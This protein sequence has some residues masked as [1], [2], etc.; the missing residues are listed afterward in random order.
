M[1]DLQEGFVDVWLSLE[2]ILDLV[3]IVD[4][5][6]KLNRL[7]VLQGWGGSQRDCHRCM[8]LDWWRTWWC[9]W[10]NRGSLLAGRSMCLQ[11]WWLRRQEVMLEIS[12]LLYVGNKGIFILYMDHMEETTQYATVSDA[13][14]AT[15]WIPQIPLS[16]NITT[17]QNL[18]LPHPGEQPLPTY[19]PWLL[20]LHL[21]KRLV[22]WNCYWILHSSREFEQYL[23]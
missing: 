1:E 11:L 22:F 8:R 14:S 15:T 6:I 21:L 7:I 9:V 10:W 23:S 2:P 18:L 17:G 20:L 5:V 19:W 13:N 4:G 12:I 3:D 16:W